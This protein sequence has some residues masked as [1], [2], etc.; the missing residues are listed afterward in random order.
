MYSQTHRARTRTR[1]AQGGR[2]LRLLPQAL[3]SALGKAWRAVASLPSRL[4]S[5][6]PADPPRLALRV[7]PDDRPLLFFFL[8]SIGKKAPA[9]RGHRPA[10]QRLLR[11]SGRTR[12]RKGF[13]MKGIKKDGT[14][15]F[16]VR[17]SECQNVRMSECQNV[18]HDES[19][20]AQG[21]GLLD[22][23]EAARVTG[24]PPGS[25][26]LDGADSLLRNY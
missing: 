5:D 3:F 24:G 6:S 16:N 8:G 26:C 25:R 7:S 4:V 2:R 10:A 9:R 19:G 1:G 13:W 20:K 11:S 17:M 21:D 18:S 22:A 23:I 15:S 14:K 12:K